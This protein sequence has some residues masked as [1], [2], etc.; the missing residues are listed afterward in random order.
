MFEFL[1]GV[2]PFNDQ[3]PDLVF[4]NTVYSI[5]VCVFEFLIGVPPFNDQTPD[6]VFQNIL[7]RGEKGFCEWEKQQCGFRPGLTQTGLYSHRSRLKA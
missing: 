5:E 6:L 2:P 7:N 4:Q 1:I 3:T